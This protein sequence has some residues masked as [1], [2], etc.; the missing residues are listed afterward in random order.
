MNQRKIQ[1]ELNIGLDVTGRPNAESNRAERAAIA[2]SWLS[3]FSTS[4]HRFATQY[5]GP[6]G[7]QIDE[8]GLF[9]SLEV[10]NLFSAV[11]EVYK[12]SQLLDQDCIAAFYPER[13][14]GLM[15]GP[16]ADQWPAFNSRYFRRF[17]V[18]PEQVAA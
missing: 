18:T 8:A 2:Q 16:A 1:M 14:D 3:A 17:D 7:T 6:D 5:P 15:I 12:L 10:N 4:S 13:G 9:L 11:R